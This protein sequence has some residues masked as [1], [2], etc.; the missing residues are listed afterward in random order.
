MDRQSSTSG[1]TTLERLRRARDQVAALKE[2]IAGMRKA[3]ED[4]IDWTVTGKAPDPSERPIRFEIRR[5]LRG[6]YDK[7][8][9]CA[10][11][12]DETTALSVS[13][14]GKMIVWDAYT[15]DKREIIFLPSNW[16]MACAFETETDRFVAAGGLDNTCTVWA[17]DP[18]ARGS[19]DASGGVRTQQEGGAPVAEFI[20]HDGFVSD[21][22]F[23]G[24]EKLLTSSG[25]GTVALWDLA[26]ASTTASLRAQARA[27][28]LP[29]IGRGAASAA[30]VAAPTTSAT[31]V[32]SDHV[33]DVMAVAVNPQDPNIFAT[34]SCDK[35]VRVWDVRRPRSVRTFE[36]HSSD[37]NDVVFFPSGMTIGSGSDD[38][39][40]RLFDLRSC[41]PVHVISDDRLQSAVTSVAF[42]RSGRLM[43]ASYTDKAARA[44]SSSGAGAGSAAGALQAGAGAGVG[45]AAGKEAEARAAM[46]ALARSGEEEAKRIAKAAAASINRGEK[47]VTASLPCHIIAW[48]VVS[49]V[50][51]FHELKGNP[52][53]VSSLA[54]NA[55]G[56]AL[57]A[58]SW[59]HD[60][61]VWA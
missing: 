17:V 27:F 35:T 61:T 7:V 15:R 51:V 41:G 57:L 19:R 60:V 16:P 33:A 53:T 37:V 48:E 45:G 3:Q 30:S 46:G 1:L 13:G 4:D 43:F 25:D 47:E 2:R 40:C 49:N 31:T 6:H 36:G 5:L 54:V 28:R 38:S 11:A 39:S 58:A 18:D 8:H 32:F 55:S 50:G 24:P 10:W 59:D 56:Q 9:A 44:S 52:K 21:I 34:G 42:S 22:K 14:D 20:G 29:G 26:T 23:V 12:G